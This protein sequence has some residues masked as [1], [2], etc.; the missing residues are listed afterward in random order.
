MHTLERIIKDATVAPWPR[1]VTLL[2]LLPILIGVPLAEDWPGLLRLLVADAF[3]LGA[4]FVSLYLHRRYLAL[5]RVAA[6][7]RRATRT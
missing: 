7:R 4:A 2:S 6:T 3:F 1:F 5:P